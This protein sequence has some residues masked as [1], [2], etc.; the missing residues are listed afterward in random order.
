M[1]DMLTTPLERVRITSIITGWVFCR[2]L[3]T[4]YRS[5]RIA[6]EHT[7][8]ETVIPDFIFHA[9]QHSYAIHLVMVRVESPNRER[10]DRASG[11]YHDLAVYPSL[12]RSQAECGAGP[13]AARDGVAAI[14]ATGLNTRSR[15]TS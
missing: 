12:Q 7:V 1:N 9:L 4:P 15:K 11:H 2:S 14:I 13:G 8:R 5:F 6:F 10:I 3:D